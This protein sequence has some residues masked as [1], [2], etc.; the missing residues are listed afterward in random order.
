[1]KIILSLEIFWS[2]FV[3]IQLSAL[4]LETSQFYLRWKFKQLNFWFVGFRLHSAVS[5]C[6]VSPAKLLSFNTTH[7]TNQMYHKISAR[8]LCNAPTLDWARFG[9]RII[10]CPFSLGCRA[11]FCCRALLTSHPSRIG[12]NSRFVSIHSLFW[13]LVP[14]K[15]VPECIRTPNFPRLHPTYLPH[16]LVLLWCSY[17]FC[18]IASHSVW[19]RFSP[20]CFSFITLCIGAA[21]VFPPTKSF[22]FSARFPIDWLSL[23]SFSQRLSF[24]RIIASSFCLLFL[25]SL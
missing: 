24:F 6:A 1:M 25:D 5:M 9:L 13:H 19:N 21:A 18:L 17:G 3:F 12:R 14:A 7:P 8:S 20:S 2:C 22:R 11:R 15:T 23:R 16:H 4:S 10:G